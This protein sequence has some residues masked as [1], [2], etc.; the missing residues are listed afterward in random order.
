MS[1]EILAEEPAAEAEMS[2]ELEDKR[3]AHPLIEADQTL[4]PYQCRADL[5]AAK[6]TSA[7]L[8]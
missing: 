2:R 1:G 8:C 6:Q 5:S 4:T 7:R 3:E